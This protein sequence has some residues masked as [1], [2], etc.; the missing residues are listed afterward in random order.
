MR[1]VYQMGQMA[2]G[3]Q[4]GGYMTNRVITRGPVNPRDSHCGVNSGTG[5]SLWGQL[6]SR[7]VPSDRS[8]QYTYYRTLAALS[9]AFKRLL[10]VPMRLSFSAQRK[11]ED[12]QTREGATSP[13]PFCC[14]GGRTHEKKI[15]GL[16]AG[17][18]K[19]QFS[20]PG[21]IRSLCQEM[22]VV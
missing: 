8:R 5:L 21:T 22:G 19:Y 20:R 1:T 18:R 7:G 6:R 15:S 4:G 12:W 14:V 9:L 11:L 2:N 10:E 13:A 3:V 16:R 17:L